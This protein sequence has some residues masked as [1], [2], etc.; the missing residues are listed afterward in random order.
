MGRI[1]RRTRAWRLDVRA[2]EVRTQTRPEAVVVE[3][4]LEIRVDGTPV[5]V[6]MRTP[7]DDFDLVLGWLHAEGLIAA[8]ADV[9]TLMHCQDLDEA[10]RPTFNVVDVAT[11]PGAPLVVSPRAVTTSSACGMCGA[12]SI[13]AT[14]R[15]SRYDLGEDGVRL[16]PRLLLEL[17]RRLRAH[18]S[19][20]E[21]TGGTHA[22][23]LFDARGELLCVR[24]DV[25]RHNAVD[26]VVGWAL[27]AQRLPLR[28]CVLVVSGRAGYE[29]VQ[30]A[31]LAGAPAMVS[32]S[33]TTSLAVEL[34]R[35]SGL[36]LVS[37]VRDE[38]LTV[39]SA[40]RR[41]DGPADAAAVELGEG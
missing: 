37:F 23:G 5:A 2:D 28:G 8:A 26:K 11:P 29:L 24:E 38:R 33:A 25:G 41:V 36:T 30:K 31:V 21:R 14:R 15:R 4:P 19:G 13:E 32:V 18:Q 40:P 6:T 12:A 34:A 27:R 9:R 10:G 16:D 7:G 17:P 39:Y 22:A 3:E 20:F 35:E 1:T